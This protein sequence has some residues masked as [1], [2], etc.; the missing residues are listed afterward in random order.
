MPTSFRALLGTASL[1]VGI[2][3]AAA[4]PAWGQKIAE[5]YPGFE[6]DLVYNA[7][8]VEHPS[9]VS[10]DD[11]GNLFVGED[12]MDMRGP[13][14]REIDRVVLIRF[15]KQTGDPASNGLLP[16]SLRRLRPALARMGLSTSCMPPTTPSFA[17]PTAT[18]W[19]T[20]AK[21]WSKVLGR[22]PANTASTIT[23]SRASAWASTI[24]FMCRSVIREFR[25]PSAAT[26]ARSRS[27][28]VASPACGSTVH[29]WKSSPRGPA[30]TS[31]WRW[32]RS[33]TSLPTTIPTT[34]SVGG[35]ALPIRCRPATT[36][37]PTSISNIPSAISAHQRARR[38]LAVW[39]G[40]LSRGGMARKI[41]GHCLFL[42]M[43]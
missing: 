30:T 2:G 4:A 41:S 1:A 20:S 7:P 23:S 37:I 25:A 10:C 39:R 34:D 42:R 32:T 11:Q 8:D 24:G 31:T 43:G 36:D 27:K 6:V 21:I 35:P 29:D 15:D 16:E 5:G 9:V 40:V 17:T 19:P 13:A 18:A 33:T 14:T 28:G 38:R 22:P 3:L 26:A 12:P